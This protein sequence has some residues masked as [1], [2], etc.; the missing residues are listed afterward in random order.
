MNPHDPNPAYPGQPEEDLG[1]LRTEAKTAPADDGR[2]LW[3]A[4]GVAVVAHLVVLLII[5]GLVVGSKMRKDPQIVAEVV[6]PTVVNKPKIEKRAV[7]KQAKSTSA[8]ASSPLA[9]MLRANAVAQIAVPEV[10]KITRSPIGLGEGDLGSGFG[11]GSGGSGMGSGATFFG[12]KAA[13]NRFV[14]CLDISGS[15]SDAQ[16]S[17]LQ[18]EFAKSVKALQPGI[19]YQVVCFAGPAWVLGSKVS[20][21]NENP[22]VSLGEKRWDFKQNGHAFDY[23]FVGP[24]SQMQKPE[25]LAV[26]GENVRKTVK[27][28]NEVRKV[29]GTDWGLALDMCML[30]NPAPNSIYLMSDG[31]TQI[32]ASKYAAEMKGRNIVLHGFSMDSSSGDKDFK[33]L[34]KGTGGTFTKIESSGKIQKVKL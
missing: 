27:N 11:A 25:W 15:M 2:K 22:T 6:A 23:S 28:M 17:L 21:G 14:F 29:Y 34:A 33:I 9:R 26:T 12:R 20:G 4:I 3:S 5:W 24:K 31:S 32:D 8:S 18:K 16:L 1:Y 7:A 30:M 10:T 13:G 19:Q